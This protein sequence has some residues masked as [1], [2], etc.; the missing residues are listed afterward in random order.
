MPQPRARE[1]RHHQ[2]ERQKH[3]RAA[4]VGLEEHQPSRQQRN[5]QRRRENLELRQTI[6]IV[7]QK[8]GQTDDRHQLADLGRLHDHE[9]EIE[10]AP[11]PEIVAAEEQHRH[12]HPDAEHVGDPAELVDQAVIDPRHRDHHQRADGGEDDVP[13]HLAGEHHALSAARQRGAVDH[14]RPVGGQRQRGRQ[15][16]RVEVAPRVAGHCGD[17]ARMAS[18]SR[19]S[20]SSVM[21]IR[22]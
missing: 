12:Q 13:L 15:Q 9:A 1:Q 17:L 3:D 10:P 11:R 4:R 20:S 19:R 21:A 16:Q 7:R 6:P 14:Q 5:Q 8:L 18:N 2:P 22:A